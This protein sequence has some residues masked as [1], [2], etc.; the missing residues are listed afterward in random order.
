MTDAEKTIDREAELAAYQGPDRVV[1]RNQF[2]TLKEAER[3]KVRSFQSGYAMFDKKLGGLATGE[4]TV[5]SGRTGEGKTLFAESWLRRLLQIGVCGCFFS[6]EVTATT[7]AEKYGDEDFIYFP[8]ELKVMDVEWL[9]DRIEEAK[10]KYECRVV[11]LDHLHFLVDMATKQNMSL[12]IGAFMRRLKTIALGLNVAI[13]LIAHQG[14]PSDKNSEPS[15]EN[16][17]DSSFI[18]QEAD[19]VLIVSR[20]KDFLG[21]ELSGMPAES[22]S[23]IQARMT[24]LPDP[25]DPYK[26]GFAIVQIAKARRTGTY[27]WPK[28]FQKVGN[29]MEE[30]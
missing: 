16:I 12:N 14:Q 21:S 20:R 2:L 27:R 4:V 6:F 22:Q 30:V 5:I 7:I 24:E 29:F 17:R 1:H 3:K 10:L 19:N 8:L 28:L 25:Q 9:Q 23:K 26:C 18:A 11:V 15:L 13:I